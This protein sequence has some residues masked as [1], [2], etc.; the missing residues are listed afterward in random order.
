MT[1]FKQ[2]E[3]ALR[4][5]DSEYKQA[6]SESDRL[7]LKEKKNFLLEIR[8]YILDASWLAKN[9]A[10]M[11]LKIILKNGTR[12]A[13]EQLNCTELSILNSMTSYSKTLRGII[14][15]NTIDLALSGNLEDARLQFQRGSNFLSF[16]DIIA[17]KDDLLPMSQSSIDFDLADCAKEIKFLQQCSEAKINNIIASLD[18]DKLAYLRYILESKKL[19]N[20]QTS[21]R[22]DLY[23][24]LL[25]TKG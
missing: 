14:G 15:E 6:A 19:T 4:S 20:A 8:K 22:L 13:A 3:E 12:K 9:P 23:K 25:K 24:V 10:K 5:I 7:V 17:I 11:R 16:S 18:S 21:M 1:I 2:L